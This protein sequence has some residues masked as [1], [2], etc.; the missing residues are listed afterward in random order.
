MLKKVV[1]QV[2]PSS[3]DEWVTCVYGYEVEAAKNR[4]FN[5]SGFSPSQRQIGMNIRISAAS[6][7][8]QRLRRIKEAAQEAFIKHTMHDAV[9]K[10]VRARA[11]PARDFTLGEAVYVYRKPLPRKGG[12]IDGRVAQ[13][14]GPDT[15]VF[16]EGPNLWI[17][18]RGEMWKCA[19][20][21]VR[22]ATP[23]EEEA[24]GLLKDEFK[25]LQME[26]GRKGSKRSFKDIS[27]WQV[28]PSGK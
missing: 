24:C 9:Q 22:S 26:L 7:D 3:Y 28:P 2:T 21:Q 27:N 18:M 8:M 6:S 16:Q 1:D 4:L 23:E 15:V 17:A 13:W 14:C 11:R 10:A 5:R 20:E 19:K 12:G 25:E